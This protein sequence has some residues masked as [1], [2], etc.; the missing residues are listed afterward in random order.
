[1][2][3]NGD[4][5]EPDKSITLGELLEALQTVYQGKND[6][7]KGSAFSGA[8]ANNSAWT[9][10]QWARNRGVLDDKWL[11]E[12]GAKRDSKNKWI[13]NL[14]EEVAHK[15]AAVFLWTL[16]DAPQK[17][18]RVPSVTDIPKKAY[19]YQAAGWALERE[20]IPWKSNGKFY[21][22][23]AATR[24]ETALLLYKDNTAEKS[25]KK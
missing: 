13:L 4:K 7:L 6:S 14:D 18:G 23:K 5:F 25:A 11:E 15:D 19:Y 24:L 22:G 3:L 17:N 16:H 9:A 12:H 21:P 10:A 8:K 2:S 20:I 1:M